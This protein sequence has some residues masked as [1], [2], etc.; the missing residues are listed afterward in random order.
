[1]LVNGNGGGIGRLNKTPASVIVAPVAACMPGPSKTRFNRGR[2][3]F[4]TRS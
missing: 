2:T 3:T 1:M 4:S